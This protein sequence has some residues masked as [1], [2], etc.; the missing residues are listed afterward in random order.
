MLAKDAQYLTVRYSQRDMHN[1]S[2]DRLSDEAMR[3]ESFD[4]LVSQDGDSQAYDSSGYD[5]SGDWSQEK[6][7]HLPS[8][9][10]RNKKRWLRVLIVLVPLLVVLGGTIALA[11]QASTSTQAIEKPKGPKVAF[12][13][14]L[15]FD[16][17]KAVNETDINDDPYFVAT[18]ML[19]YQLLHDPVTK[20]R[21]DAPLI[22]MAAPNT[23]E[24]KIDRLERDGLTIFRITDPID[25]P[26]YRDY[27][28]KHF[29]GVWNKLEIWRWTQYD[30]VIFVDS[31]HLLIK[32]LDEILQETET[33]VYQNKRLV[34]TPADEGEQPSEYL[35]A[36]SPELKMGDYATGGNHF[37]PTKDE[38][39]PGDHGEGYIN[40]GLFVIKPDLKMFDYFMS[41]M[42]Q[43]NKF[44]STYPEQNL[45][46]Y[47]FRPDGNLP[48][49]MLDVKWSTHF[50]TMNA[51]KGGAHAVHEKWW[52]DWLEPAFMNWMVSWRWRM[53]GYYTAWD[54]L[55][56]H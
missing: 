50:P 7:Y 31:D 9:R 48:W 4:C 22:V 20:N 15:T 5:S 53:E 56:Q 6:I 33:Q 19:G 2:L 26:L 27:D 23:S 21:L 16:P 55:M 12:A 52:M 41:V 47:V 25:P 3:K 11:A 28:T 10:S 44:D 54:S 43:P 45:F 18:R 35:F 51:V 29:I 13:T 1:A 40:S 46:N 30:R 39:N 49:K 37:P 38:Y 42:S 14:L 8:E 34:Q 17:E 24:A 36:P 32:P